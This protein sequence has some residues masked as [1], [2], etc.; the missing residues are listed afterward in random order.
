MIVNRQR[1]DLECY[2]SWIDPECIVN[3]SWTDR[4]ST[5]NRLG[6]GSKKEVNR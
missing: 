4:E 3:R 5:V 2:R 6:I 1:I